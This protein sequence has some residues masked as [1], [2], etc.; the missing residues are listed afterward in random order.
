MKFKSNYE[1]YKKHLPRTRLECY[2]LGYALGMYEGPK[3]VE[4]LLDKQK[5]YF[6]NESKEYKDISK[7]LEQEKQ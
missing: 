7:E 1:E 5:E 6:A 4:E 2:R 3:I